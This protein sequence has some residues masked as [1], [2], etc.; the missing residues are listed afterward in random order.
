MGPAAKKKM[1]TYN[2]ESVYG[3]VTKKGLTVLCIYTENEFDG[4]QH[5]HSGIHICLVHPSDDPI[6]NLPNGANLYVLVPS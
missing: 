1:V 5:D 3:P 4:V 2:S 6:C